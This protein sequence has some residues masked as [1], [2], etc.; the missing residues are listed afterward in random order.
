MRKQRMQRI[1]RN[2][3]KQ[4][5]WM[6]NHVWLFILTVAGWLMYLSLTDK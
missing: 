2:A 6:K 4:I 5:E 1:L 3:D